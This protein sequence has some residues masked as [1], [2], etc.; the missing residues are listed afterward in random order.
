MRAGD[1]DGLAAL[2]RGVPHPA[3]HRAPTRREPRPAF[4]FTGQ[5]AQRLGMGRE[6]AAAFPDFAET[7][8]AVCAAFRPYLERPLR[9]VIDGAD[10]ELLN[11][12]DYAQP[13]LFAFE[14]ALHALYT[15]CGVRPELLAGHSIGELTAAHVAGVLSRPDAVRLVAARGRLMAALPAGGAM[16][17]V[18]ATEAEVEKLLAEA[19]DQVSIAAVNGPESVV[20]S[21]AEDA[22]TALAERVG[23]RSDRLRVSHAFHSPLLEPMLAGFR[24]VAESVTYHRPSIPVVSALAGD[25]DP[26][27]A[28]Y[29]VR[30]VRE[31]VRFA[32]AVAGLDA[33]GATALVEIGPAA[34]LA[35][36]AERCLPADST[37][38][39]VPGAAG[40][41]GFLDALATLHVHGAPVDWP[42]V[43]AGSGARR[44]DLPTYPFQRQRFWLDTAAHDA[45]AG[46][47]PLLGDPQPAADGP[48]VRH[49]GVLSATRQP[50]LADHVIGDD[51][52]VPAAALAELAFRAA[53]DPALHAGPAGAPVRAA[54]RLA[55]LSL[56][57]PLILAGPADVQ[58]VVDAPDGTGDRPLTI[59]ARPAGSAGRWTSHATATVT[60]PTGHAPAAPVAWPPP[61][62]R[63]VTVDYA[64]LAD[65]GFHYG[66][67]F[68]AVTAVW[69][70][71]DDVYAE[72]NLAPAEAVTAGRFGVHPAL[73]DAA[74]HASL[75]A[76][77]PDQLRVPFT[78]SGVEL[79]A[80]GAATA[81]VVLSPIGP[82]EVRVTVTDRSGGPVVT[83][84]SLVT[85]RIDIQDAA[86]AAARRS[87]HRLTWVPAPAVRDETPYEIFRPTAPAS[88]AP[89][90]ARALLAGTL[91][92]LTDWLAADRP[93]R[94][95][96]VTERATGADPDPAAAAVWGL[97]GSAQTEHPGRFTVVDLCGAPASET[98]LPRAAALTEPRVAVRDGSVLAPRLALAGPADAT[99]PALSPAATVLI[100]GG[101][102]ALGAIL[103]RHLVAE[104]GVR[105]LVLAG[106][107]GVA[108]SWVDALDARITVTACDVGDRAAVDR[109]VAACGPDLTA[110]FHLAGVLDDGVLTAM[111]PE[112][113]DAVLAP[114]A[115]AAWHLHE[116]TR[117]LN[118]A[119][120]VLYSS[121]SG[122]LGRP[123]QANYAAAN[124]F[125][126]AVA[127]HRAALGLPARSLAWGLWADDD[128]GMAGRVTDGPARRGLTGDGIRALTAGQGTALLDRA[129]RTAEPLLVPIA[130]DVPATDAPAI[131]SGLAP[132]A[133]VAAP[134][135]APATGA[136]AELGG[137]RETL[138]KLPEDERTGALSTLIH[139]EIAAVLGFTDGAA[140]DPGRHFT[141]LGFDSLAAVQLRNRLSAFTGVRL[142]ATI[143]LDHPTLAELTAH[144]YAALAGTLPAGETGPATVDE[145]P[146][147]PPQPAAVTERFTAIYHRVIRDRGAAAAMAL[148]YLAAHGLPTF[149]AEHRAEHAPAPVRLATGDPDRPILFFVPGY[150]ALHDPAPTG[151]GRALDGD[152][153]LHML[154]HPGFGARREVPDGVPT[155]VRLHAD[156]VRAVAGDRPFV[157]IGDSTGG[158]VAH[159]VATHLAAEGLPPRGV[160]LIDSHHGTDGHDDQRALALVTVD[161]NRPAELFHGL[162]S[163]ATMIAGGAYVRIFEDWVPEPAGLPTL[164]LRAAPTREMREIDPERDWRPRWPLPHD[165]VDV[166]GDHYTTL[167]TE[168]G[169]TVAAIRGWL[170]DRESAPSSPRTVRTGES[171]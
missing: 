163:D 99:P 130:I 15:A 76:Q 85:R 33:A 10:A 161:R 62:A 104:Y 150:L 34:V 136:A 106:R 44:R 20:L 98:A 77:P 7:Y 78:L 5:G 138:A 100:T 96:V 48:Q 46:T 125:V 66:A 55:E 170:H 25:A 92:R 28:D 49:S 167:T 6:L 53:S 132:A 116:A 72:V 159:A 158:G 140:L 101:T 162:F 51:L 90:R 166:P 115:D 37:A 60:A 12:T 54:V 103:A 26:A 16:V 146:G 13:A 142:E 155:L 165:V 129:L 86:G 31:A 128:G 91:A 168:V 11:R 112:R 102:G 171:G 68:R 122:V 156:T 14:V 117:G 97:A 19:G 2:A 153:D 30:H 169:A 141:E 41:A 121:A 69:R 38:V 95:V 52:I 73:L 80:T 88:D 145:V 160:V 35:V 131:L 94:L 65:A 17:A 144:V 81:R 105:N 84:D 149:G 154:V 70:G 21:G 87:L 8:D 39:L 135:A 123:G 114:K 152:Y 24:A 79:H 157:L 82:D 22:V 147:V 119:A 107:R 108:P 139:D 40:L 143:A 109:L 83:I 47:H 50:W 3:V 74:L 9:E 1:R 71:P 134:G 110:V 164:L 57:T 133:P 111:T 64:R 151:L 148:R 93:G 113:I 45:G 120:F 18:R 75:L 61:G 4:L 43:Y 42:Q 127:A 63:P 89:A 32:D 29:W 58:V 27:T 36:L 56:R 124:A 59:W 118:L 137:W 126:D 23:G 67:A